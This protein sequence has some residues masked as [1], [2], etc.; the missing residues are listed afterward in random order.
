MIS[1]P[2]IILL[3]KVAGISSAKAIQEVK[4]K[5]SI[6]KIGHGGTLDPGA[7]GL[8]VCLLNGATRLASFVEHGEKIYSGTF[9]IGTVT[10]SDDIFGEVISKT[11]KVPS[12]DQISKLAKNFLGKIQQIPPNVSAVKVNGQRA[13]KAAR[14]GESLALKAREVEVMDFE[15][16]PTKE[17]TIVN[18]KI[19]C[20][21]GTYIRSLARD[22]GDLLGC[23]ACVESLRRLRSFPFDIAN[24]KTINE[25]SSLDIIPWDKLFPN[26]K[27]LIL[28]EEQVRMIVAGNNRVFSDIPKPNGFGFG[29]VYEQSS[30]NPL[31]L[32]KVE[33][34]NWKIAANILS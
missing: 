22:L 25:L 15:L 10:T 23:G 30:Q 3:D 4:N 21:R 16:S 32:L 13:Y 29:I 33:G 9:R 12:F 18:Y 8:L 14:K 7:T 34:D 17:S 24:S 2:G 27:A 19:T 6:K 31:G 5:L 20:S 28:P 26:S 11:D 1:I